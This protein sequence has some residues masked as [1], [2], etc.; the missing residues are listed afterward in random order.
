MYFTCNSINTVNTLSFFLQE[1]TFQSDCKAAAA[2]C[3]N[4]DLDGKIDLHEVKLEEEETLHDMQIQEGGHHDDSQGENVTFVYQKS[5]DSDSA[6]TEL[7]ISKEI[8]AMFKKEKE[9]P[10]LNLSG[11]NFIST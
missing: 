3:Y 2:F 4:K 5:D 7:T 6:E 8:L 11:P 1:N 9:I 10:D